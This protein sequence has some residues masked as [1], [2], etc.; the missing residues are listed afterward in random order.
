VTQTKGHERA[1]A[2]RGLRDTLT[3]RSRHRSHATA[4]KRSQLS[5]RLGHVLRFERCRVEA[6]DASPIRCDR[7][8]QKVD[9]LAKLSVADRRLPLDRDEICLCLRQPRGEGRRAAEATRRDR[10]REVVDLAS[11]RGDARRS[12]LPSRV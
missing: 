4:E 5:A 3:A 2:Y 10:V 8:R 11:K 12:S 9:H 1:G 7:L 6:L